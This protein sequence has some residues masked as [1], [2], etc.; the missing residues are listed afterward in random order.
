MI[1]NNERNSTTPIPSLNKDSPTIFI[2]TSFGA[3]AFVNI[4]NTAIGSVGAT[5]APNNR[6]YKKL[7]G[8]WKSWNIKYKIEPM[9]NVD[10][11]TPATAKTAIELRFAFNKELSVCNAPANSRKLNITS[12]NTLLKS[13]LLTKSLAQAGTVGNS[14]PVTISISEKIIEVIITPIVSGSFKNLVL[15]YAK[16]A[17]IT[18]SIVM[19]TKMLMKN[20]L[21]ILPFLKTC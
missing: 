21:A 11:K 9:S 3:P 16:A 20:R 2:S 12:S 19:M 8:R 1:S 10:S 15:K 7:A 6:Q 17:V 13:I 4:P 14:N 5:N 18:T